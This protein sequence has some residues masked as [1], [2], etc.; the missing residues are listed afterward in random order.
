MMLSTQQLIHRTQQFLEDKPESFTKSRVFYI[1]SNYYY[2]NNWLSKIGHTI[3]VA[4]CISCEIRDAQYKQEQT[5]TY[6][7]VGYYA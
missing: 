6:Q 2:N 3:L 5:H 1:L 4:Y 7:G